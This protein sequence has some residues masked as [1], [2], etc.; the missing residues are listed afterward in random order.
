M[1]F[2]LL[3]NQFHLCCHPPDTPEP[4][5]KQENYFCLCL[6]HSTILLLSL[7][8]HRLLSLATMCFNH[9]AVI[10]DCLCYLTI[11]S[12]QLCIQLV[13]SC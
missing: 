6:L 7:G 2:L 10:C 13:M 4:A 9:Y 11:I 1:E 5:E 8:G 12:S 3:G